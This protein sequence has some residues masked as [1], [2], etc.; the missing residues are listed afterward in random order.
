M[1]LYPSLSLS[2][3]PH[4]LSHT[5]HHRFIVVPDQLPRLPVPRRQEPPHQGPD[6]GVEE[7]DPFGRVVADRGNRLHGDRK[8]VEGDPIGFHQA[9]PGP[10]ITER[11]FYRHGPLVTV[12]DRP[13]SARLTRRRGSGRLREM[14]R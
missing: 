3:P 13:T 9:L 10:G 12:T 4:V 5:H 6:G 14:S 1:S 8:D 11:D 7:L 2:D